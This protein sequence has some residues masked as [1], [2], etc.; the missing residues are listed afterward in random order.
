MTEV[1]EP[2]D[3]IAADSRSDPDPDRI[4]GHRNEVILTG[5]LHREPDERLLMPSR[6]TV[7]SF[8]LKVRRPPGSRGRPSDVLDCDVWPE[9]LQ[10]AVLRWA[11]DDLIEVRGAIRR[12]RFQRDRHSTWESFWQ[13][14]VTT[15][16]RLA[17]ASGTAKRTGHRNLVVVSSDAVQEA[18]P[19]DV[20]AA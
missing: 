19:G 11:K 2:A 3:D 9:S 17:H 1:P 15:A 14:E 8:Q 20:S 12:R 16:R 13:I 6:V 10:R 7:V 4:T 5:L 18:A